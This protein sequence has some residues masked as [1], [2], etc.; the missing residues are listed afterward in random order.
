MPP[1]MQPTRKPHS[2][3]LADEIVERVLELGEEE[4][5]LVRVVE[6][7][8][9]LHQVLERE[10]FASTPA[11]LDR[12]RLHGE[13]LEFGDLGP[14]VLGV[15]GQRDRLQDVFQ[16][17]AVAFFHFLQFVRDRAGPAAPVRAISWAFFKPYIEPPGPVFQGAAARRRCSTPDGVDTGP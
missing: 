9:L 14:H 1:W 10:S 2:T 16:P 11:R 13:L 6:E 7:A 3:S 15:P 17:F 8:L 4:Q 12:L 5:P